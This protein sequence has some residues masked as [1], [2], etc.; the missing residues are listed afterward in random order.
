MEKVKTLSPYETGRIIGTNAET[1]R[2]G[3]RS[4]RFN[5]GTAIPPKKEGGRW[6]Y[7]IIA[8]KVYE[9]AGISINERKEENNANTIP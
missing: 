7:N 9:Y 8:S 5:F 1:V 6:I 4:Q 2:A 3:L